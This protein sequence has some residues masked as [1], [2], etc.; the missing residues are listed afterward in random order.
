MHKEALGQISC[1]HSR[2]IVTQLDH[3]SGEH[4]S[5]CSFEI[6]VGIS[7]RKNRQGAS[8]R[9]EIPKMQIRKWYVPKKQKNQAHE[10]SHA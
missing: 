10:A 6:A 7:L 3:N 2:G 4:M 5:L 8:K 1:A 9:V